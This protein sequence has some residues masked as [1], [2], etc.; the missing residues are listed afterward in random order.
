VNKPTRRPGSTVPHAGT[1]P[2]GR[3]IRVRLAPAAGGL[4]AVQQ[5][6]LRSFAATGRPPEQAELAEAL[7]PYGGSTPRVLAQLHA[8][9]FLRLDDTGRIQ[10]AYP[11]SAA[12]T[13]HR[14]QIAGGPRVYAMCAIDALGIAPMLGAAVTIRSADPLTGAPI[15]VHVPAAGEAAWDP[16]TTVVFD[17]RV[18]RAP[19]GPAADIA[20]ST[21]NFFTGPAT[22][23]SWAGSRP[24]I[25]GTIL[26]QEEARQIAA[27]IFGPLL[28]GTG[29]W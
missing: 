10:A 14:V 24:D 15:T 6:V 23:A 9:D 4:R 13:G 7:A 17:G 2:P 25:T 20:C 11:F 18:A 26:R 19:H 27:Q 21:I 1:D 16:V 29:H 3:I 22:A 5:A 8:G 28:N 12:P